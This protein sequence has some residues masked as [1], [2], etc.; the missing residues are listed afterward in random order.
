MQDT[1]R[2]RDKA[3]TCKLVGIFTVACFMGHLLKNQFAT[4]SVTDNVHSA[5]QEGNDN[6]DANTNLGK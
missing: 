4:G 6:G 1:K 5:K 2:M 3:H